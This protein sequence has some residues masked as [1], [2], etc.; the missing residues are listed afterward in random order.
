M[1]ERHLQIYKTFAIPFPF[2]PTLAQIS[3]IR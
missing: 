3:N 1:K 2:K